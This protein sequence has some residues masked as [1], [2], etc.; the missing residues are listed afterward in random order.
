MNP[1]TWNPE[2]IK[3]LKAGTHI[4]LLPFALLPCCPVAFFP[5]AFRLSPRYLAALLPCCLAALL[6]CCLKNNYRIFLN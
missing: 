4:D 5:F 2:S 1:E 6:P 3:R